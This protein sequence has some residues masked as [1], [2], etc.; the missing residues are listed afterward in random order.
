MKAQVAALF[1]I[2]ALGLVFLHAPQAVAQSNSY[3]STTTTTAPANGNEAASGQQEMT[4]T[5]ATPT[6][7]NS[8]NSW[9]QSVT[10]AADNAEL[11]TE[12]VYHQ[13]ARDSKN[14]SL[15]AR[16]RAML[17]ENK[18]TRESD[19]L[20]SANDGIVTLTGRVPSEQ[21]ARDV[22]QVAANVYGVKAIKNHLDYPHHG[23]VVTSPDAVSTGIAHPAYSDTAPVENAPVQ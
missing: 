4:T 14:F 8:A 15:M 22:Q 3:S 13:L 17:Y 5:T 18:L 11:T 20:V 6:A 16:V 19:V 7:A 12:K 9:E 23:G 21:A 1:S 10:D 2:F